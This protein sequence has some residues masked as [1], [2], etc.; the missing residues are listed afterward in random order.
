MTKSQRLTL[1]LKKMLSMSRRHDMETASGRQ[2]ISFSVSRESSQRSWSSSC[3]SLE[4]SAKFDSE[5][6]DECCSS[7]PP[8]DVPDGCLPVYVGRERRRFVIPTAYLSNN[9]FRALLA[10]SED[11]YGLRGD[12]G[13]RIACSPD[14]FEHFLWWLQGGTQS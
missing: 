7:T 10:K 3:R 5:D 1:F 4:R 9:T 13:L 11:E 2:L 12:G 6:E 14:V 8:N